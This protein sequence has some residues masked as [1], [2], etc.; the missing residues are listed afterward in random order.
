MAQP[1]A[2]GGDLGYINAVFS[3]AAKRIIFSQGYSFMFI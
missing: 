1:Q 3:I 2:V